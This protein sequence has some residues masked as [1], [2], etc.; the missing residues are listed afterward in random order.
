MRCKTGIRGT[1]PGRPG[2]RVATKSERAKPHGLRSPM[3]VGEIGRTKRLH[4]LSRRVL[5]GGPAVNGGVKNIA[6]VTRSLRYLR[7]IQSVY[8]HISRPQPR[9][10]LPVMMSLWK[11]PSE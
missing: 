7:R 10:H 11:K 1:G 2:I 6:S 5:D 3:S 9:N 8:R 4:E